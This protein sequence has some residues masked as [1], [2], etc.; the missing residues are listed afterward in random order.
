MNGVLLIWFLYVCFVLGSL[1]WRDFERN[2]DKLLENLEGKNN[3]KARFVTVITLI[4]DSKMYL[5][6]GE[7]KGEI[8]MVR[9]GT[10]GFGYDSVFLPEGYSKTF[11]EMT[12]YEK[13]GISH[14]GMAVRKLMAFLQLRIKNK[15]LRIDNGKWLMVNGF[16]PR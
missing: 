16:A 14:R 2:I 5:F 15:K 10:G 4:F 8:T 13:N 9:R 1:Q 3:R 6:E 12:L 7:V 11:G